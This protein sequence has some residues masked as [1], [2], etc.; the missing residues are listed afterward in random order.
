[1]D[2][3]SGVTSSQPLNPSARKFVRFPNTALYSPLVYLPQSI[4]M[5][6]GR[7]LGVSAP[8]LCL[9]GRICNL[10][11]WVTLVFLAIRVTLVFLAIRITPV[12]KWLF[13][14]LALMPMSLFIATSF[15]DFPAKRT[16]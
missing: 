5:A 12:Y 16:I 2:Q 13:F 9:F 11:A 14:V 8:T 4:G 10:L 6:V 15:V 7:L 1:M 3:L